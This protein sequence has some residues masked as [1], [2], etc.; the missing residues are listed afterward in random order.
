MHNGKI[1]QPAVKLSPTKSRELIPVVKLKPVAGV[2]ERGRGI[3]HYVM[4]ALAV[5]FVAAMVLGLI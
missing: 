1:R 4:S 3:M 2:S 5:G